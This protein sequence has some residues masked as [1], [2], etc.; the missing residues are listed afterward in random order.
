VISLKIAR[1][2][3]RAAS[4]FWTELTSNEWQSNF[5]GTRKPSFSRSSSIC[6]YCHSPRA[7]GY[8]MLQWNKMRVKS[9]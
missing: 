9:F 4:V 5:F 1:I 7:I 6:C 8:A 2:N 3:M